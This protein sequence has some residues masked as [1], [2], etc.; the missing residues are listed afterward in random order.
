M[1]PAYTASNG[2]NKTEG[3]DV[4]VNVEEPSAKYELYLLTFVAFQ[5]FERSTM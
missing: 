1:P 4:T 5:V 2:L 3:E